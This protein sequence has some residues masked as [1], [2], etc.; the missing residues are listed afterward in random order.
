MDNPDP[1]DRLQRAEHRPRDLPHLH[2]GQ[3]AVLGQE[4][5]KRGAR[6]NR[7][8]GPHRTVRLHDILHGNDVR[9]AP[10]RCGRAERPR[11]PHR[12][13]LP[14]LPHLLD[15]HLAPDLVVRPPHPPMPAGSHQT[16]ELIAPGKHP[17]RL[18]PLH[19]APSRNC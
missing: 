9:M 16:D 2:D 19:H 6:N 10:Q 12:T 1:V 13:H 3:P 17:P 7:H 11:H 14:H 5:C 8:D 18:H 15:R 4:V